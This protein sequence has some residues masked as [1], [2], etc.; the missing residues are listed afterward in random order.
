[1]WSNLRIAELPGSRTNQFLLSRKREVHAPILTQSRGSRLR[2]ASRRV[3]APPVLANEQ[4]PSVGERGHG[5]RTG[6]SSPIE[7]PPGAVSLSS[8][9]PTGRSWLSP[10]RSRSAW[11]RPT[12]VTHPTGAAMYAAGSDARKG[13]GRRIARSLHEVA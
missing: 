13:D 1:V 2:S 3:R 8:T 11:L 5:G 9:S 4:W 6:G 12:R 10:F 7:K